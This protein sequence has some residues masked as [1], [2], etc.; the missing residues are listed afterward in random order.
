MF[1]SITITRLLN[2]A[3]RNW[4]TSKIGTILKIW[5]INSTETSKLQTIRPYCIICLYAFFCTFCTLA[6]SSCLYLP[7]MFN[8]VTSWLTFTGESKAIKWKAATFNYQIYKFSCTLNNL[9][10]F[11]SH[12]KE[13]GLN[14]CSKNFPFLYHQI[15]P[16]SY[17]MLLLISH[18][19]HVQFCATPLD[20][21][22]PGSPVPG[23]LQARTLEWVAISLSNAWKWK[24]K[25][26]TLS[27]VWLFETLWTTAYKTPP[28]MGF[29]RQEY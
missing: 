5:P 24:V 6:I 8:V 23:I 17:P 28:S 4:T 26:K 1:I 3:W 15:S 12:Y 13:V 21:S 9:F 2:A 25:V 22:P 19:S 7:L 18:F 20:S 14:L 16:L 27:C 29:S 10:L 11:P